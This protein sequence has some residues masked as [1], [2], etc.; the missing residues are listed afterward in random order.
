V[1]AHSEVDQAA[2]DLAYE[3]RQL[4]VMETNEGLAHG[5]V[6]SAEVALLSVKF[7]PADFALWALI[8]G[9]LPIAS[10]CGHGRTVLS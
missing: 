1:K 10:P 6:G 3:N 7:V 8:A 5:W 4:V 9:V 2:T